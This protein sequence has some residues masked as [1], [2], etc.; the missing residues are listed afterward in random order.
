M[1]PSFDAHVLPSNRAAWYDIDTRVR[2]RLL[3]PL[4]SAWQASRKVRWNVRVVGVRCRPRGEQRGRTAQ[5]T[6]RRALLYTFEQDLF[7]LYASSA[8]ASA[9]AMARCVA[10]NVYVPLGPT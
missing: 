9:S 3:K 4:L 5:A 10:V 6:F 8:E 7:W 1:Q 2:D